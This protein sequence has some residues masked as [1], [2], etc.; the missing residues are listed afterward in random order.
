MARVPE[1]PVCRQRFYLVVWGQKKE[2]REKAKK[3]KRAMMAANSP[4]SL[5][6]VILVRLASL[7]S[8]RD[9]SR[10]GLVRLAR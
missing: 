5:S 9:L 8:N 2:M 6:L 3:E 1:Q 7:V 4:V 10:S